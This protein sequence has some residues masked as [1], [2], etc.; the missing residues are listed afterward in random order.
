LTSE[1]ACIVVATL[2]AACFRGLSRELY[3]ELCVRLELNAELDPAELAQRLVDMGYTSVDLVEAAGQFS[4]RGGIVDLFSPQYAFPLRV[5]FFGDQIESLRLFE[6]STQRSRAELVE[7]L[8]IPCSE[9]SYRKDAIARAKASLVGY[10]QAVGTPEEQLVAL[11]DELDRRGHF[12]GVEWYLTH[13]YAA[14]SVREWMGPEALVVLDGAAALRVRVAE[15][16][17]E[18]EWKQRTTPSGSGFQ[19]ISMN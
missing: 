5:E 17:R 9:I 13:F 1:R 16:D 3:R 19:P 7:G 8:A 4:K 10:A 14:A 18:L 6:P 15:L 2:E 12:P 11:L